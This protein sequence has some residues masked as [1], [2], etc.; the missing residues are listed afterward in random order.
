MSMRV[1]SKGYAFVSK[2]SYFYFKFEKVYRSFCQ[3]DFQW[4]IFAIFNDNMFFFLILV[5]MEGFDVF[6]QMFNFDVQT[7][8]TTSQNLTHKNKNNIHVHHLT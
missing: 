3:S 5:C 1:L 6:Y 2:V 7:D 8:H 4:D